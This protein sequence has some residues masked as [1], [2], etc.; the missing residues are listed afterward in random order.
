MLYNIWIVGS[1]LCI[2]LFG[3]SIF[4]YYRDKN[5]GLA[6]TLFVL[7]LFYGI[8]D[9]IISG[10]FPLNEK[11]NIVTLSFRIYGIGSVS[12]IYL[13][14]YNTLYKYFKLIIL[15]IVFFYFF[16]IFPTRMIFELLM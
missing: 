14:L 2:S 16:I 5:F 3:Y 8:G 9:E 7:I 15:I 13:F 1:D 6:T 4:Q 12:N 11:K 10:L